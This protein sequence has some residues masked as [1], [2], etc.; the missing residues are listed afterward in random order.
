MKTFALFSDE[1]SEMELVEAQTWGG[2]FENHIRERGLEWS[3]MLGT[4][5]TTPYPHWVLDLYD[6]A[7]GE[8]T[9]IIVPFEYLT[10]EIA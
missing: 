1:T 4:R 8:E 3:S 5:D 7:G 9:V 6:A 2:A 10:R